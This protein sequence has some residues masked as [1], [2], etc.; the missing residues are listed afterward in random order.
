MNLGGENLGEVAGRVE[1]LL[2]FVETGQLISCCFKDIISYTFAQ[3]SA[4]HSINFFIS[5]QFR[6]KEKSLRSVRREK[7]NLI[8]I[9]K[10]KEE[11]IHP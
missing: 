10:V 3:C 7:A 8:N 6:K 9:R 4:F 5:N 1:L 2:H 11:E